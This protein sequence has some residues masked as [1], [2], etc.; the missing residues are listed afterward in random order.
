MV[1]QQYNSERERTGMRWIG[2]ALVTILL[3]S[4]AAAAQIGIDAD[5]SGI[6]AAIES[7]ASNSDDVARLRCFDALSDGANPA[8]SSEESSTREAA[9][10]PRERPPSAS[11]G[12]VFQQ[13]EDPFENRNTSYAVLQ[14]I[15]STWV[16]RDAPREL[17]VRCD[18]RGGSEIFVTSAGYIG[19]RDDRS[20]VRFRFGDGRP[21]SERW[22]SSTNGTAA[23]LP[24]SH[25]DFR[26]GLATR[27]DFVFELTDYRGSRSSARFDGLADNDQHLEYVLNGCR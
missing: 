12:W 14:S 7:C 1:V 2:L 5:S 8:E 18:G 19:G 9:I 13:Q 25:R 20:Q 11:G 27:Q 24:A 23:F 10:A 15:R 22:H 6:R 21:T 26:S 16:G 4:G 17:I 3:N